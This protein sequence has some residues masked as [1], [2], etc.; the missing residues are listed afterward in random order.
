MV[1]TCPMT[2]MPLLWTHLEPVWAEEQEGPY[3][4]DYEA[5]FN[6]LATAPSCIEPRVMLLCATCRCPSVG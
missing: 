6:I 5:N 3:Y 4:L 2:K 1:Y